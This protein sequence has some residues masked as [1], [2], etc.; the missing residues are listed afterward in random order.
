MRKLLGF[1][2]LA[3]VGAGLAVA[4]G[5][6]LARA[7]RRGEETDDEFRRVAVMSGT[8]LACQ[9]EEFRGGDLLVGM[10]GVNLDLTGATLAPEGA[11]LRVRGVMGG[12][13]V[14]VPSSWRVTG[15]LKG[16]GGINLDTTPV[17]DLPPGGP[18]LRVDALVLMGG[19]NVEASRLPRPVID[20]RPQPAS[21]DTAD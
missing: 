4:A 16:L 6:A 3:G 13:N 5:Q 21:A 8:E 14:V 9:A 17:D 19:V 10:G 7:G 18:G 2:V 12:V 15:D 11:V 1:T 20:L